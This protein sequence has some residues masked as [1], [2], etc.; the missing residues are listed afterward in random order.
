MTLRPQPVARPIE[1]G[2][3]PPSLFDQS[4]APQWIVDAATR[5]FLAVNESALRQSGFERAQLAAMTL[6]ELWQ[7]EPAPTPAEPLAEGG[8]SRGRLG[9]ADGRM[10]DVALT[11]KRIEFERRPAWLVTIAD[12]SREVEL[13]RELAESHRKENRLAELFEEASDWFWETDANNVLTYLSPNVETVLGLPIDAYV[14]KRLS[15]TP[16]VAI[17][18]EAAQQCLA[19]IKA[20]RPYKDFIYSRKL[21][22]GRTIWVNSSGVP[23]YGRHN[24][25]KG[26][27]GIA[28]DITAQVKAERDLRESEQRFKELFEIA[29]DHY[30]ESDKKYCVS[31][32]SPNYETVTG[33]PVADIVGRRLD[34]NRRISIDPDI[35]RMVVQA[36]KAKKPYRG[37]IYSY[38]FPD[39]RKRWI[40]ISGIPVFGEDGALIGYRGVGADITERRE[41]EQAAQLARR[42]LHDALSYVTQ[43]FVVYNSENRVAAYNQAFVDLHRATGVNTPVYEGVP[44]DEIVAW[45][46]RVGFYA[47]D[48][49]TGPV[50]AETL[51]EAFQDGHEHTYHLADGRWMLVVYRPLPGGGRVGL[52]TDVTAMVNAQIEADRANKAK[53]IFLATI[54]HEIRT[55]LNG[56]LGM[57]RAMR[58]DAL[59]HE[60]RRKLDVIERSGEA[61]LALLNDIL[62][63]SKIEAGKV[64]LER[65]DFD[66]GS[67]LRSTYEVFLAITAEKGIA[68]GLDIAAAEGVYHG[69]PTRVRQI[70]SNLLS[71]AIKFTERGRIDVQALRTESGIRL[72]VRDTGIGMSAETAARMFEKF[73]QADASTTRK[74]GGT[75]LGLSICRELARLMGGSIAVASTPGRGSAF[76]VDLPLPYLGPVPP[77]LEA[78]PTDP[79]E[80]LAGRTAPLRVLVAEDNEINQRVLRALLNAVSNLAPLIV[81]NGALAIEAWEAQDWDLIF[82]DV[83][84]PVMDGVTATRHIRSRERETGRRRTPIIALTAN[85]MSHQIDDYLAIGMDSHV[86]KP[87]E[88]NALFAALGMAKAERPM[89]RERVG[90]TPESRFSPL[91]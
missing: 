46:L 75:G 32:I 38:E 91:K 44:L 53:S 82:M 2:C 83:N 70:V 62:D 52:W 18:P 54:S 79:T 40:S 21:P 56:V 65:I 81:A 30:W 47:E 67:L 15:D 66:L 26:Y 28:R 49:E 64:E 88:P 76:T 74:F 78:L 36:Y 50:T 71:N 33:I 45:Q 59:S 42:R 25:Y 8:P 13:E 58:F 20:R 14:G 7:A 16:G 9:R 77:A 63:I 89:V 1:E 35:G 19:A 72:I 27:R 80:I 17:E 48:P 69:D 55:P 90:T 60:Q 29:A 39:G 4:P 85:A 11:A 23:Y 6:A 43:P 73:S 34:E 68:T 61:L 84:M 22:D 5:R 37:F 51:Q 57:T 10:V 31:Y 87:F 12:I 24:A 86:A 3:A 41:A